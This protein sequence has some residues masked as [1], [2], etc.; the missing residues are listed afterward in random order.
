MTACVAAPL[1]C[2][3]QRAFHAYV[4]VEDYMR[5]VHVKTL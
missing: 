4:I 2:R 1:P 5:N 3:A